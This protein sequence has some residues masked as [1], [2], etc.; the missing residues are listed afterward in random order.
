MAM[1]LERQVSD[2]EVQGVYVV[3]KPEMKSASAL[4]VATTRFG[5]IEVEPDL[6]ITF[7]EGLIGFEKF[8][9]YTV[10][11]TDERGALRWLQSLEEPSLAF[12][13]ILPGLFRP[14]YV[15]AIT[16]QDASFLGLTPQIPAIVF[17]VVTVPPG[18][19]RDM[20]ANLLG[21]LV[22]NPVSR[23]G[24]QVILQDE[25]YT[26]KHR[27]MDELLQGLTGSAQPS[28]TITLDTSRGRKKKEKVAKT[29]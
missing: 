23:I 16:E 14:D 22:I 15:P 17:A 28:A 9:Q 4:Q 18:N 12:P 5:T 21:P 29:A 25:R 2:T 20:T 7:P 24:K 10:V 26:T 27:V 11:C 8:T 6:V 3:E 13:I 1:V 19:P